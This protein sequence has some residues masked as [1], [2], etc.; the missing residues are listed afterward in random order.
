MAIHATVT[1][2]FI[3]VNGLR[4]HYA[5]WGNDRAQPMI[6]LHGLRSFARVWD[7]VAHALCDRYHILALDQRGR[8]DS[9]WA[10]DGNYFTEAYVSDLEQFVGQLRLDR[11]ILVG[12]SMGGANTIVYAARHPEKVAAAVIE[13]MGPRAANPSQ[14]MMRIGQELDETPKEFR[15]WAEAEAFW[16]NQRPLISQEAMQV[17]LQATLKQPPDGKIVWKYD[18]E[19]I[20]KA[21]LNTDPARQV[22]LWP[23]VRNLKCPTLVVRGGLSDI[24]S[25]ETAEA[26]AKDNPNLRWVEVPK[27]THSVHEDNLEGFNQEVGRFL[28]GLK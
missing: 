9:D 8:G 10:P 21:R 19:G 28:N 13:D 14:G 18:L 27:A 2:R 26:M 25:R 5:D 4:I 22:D 24:L 23:H 7:G 12:H 6:M 16:R 3:K 11:C 15:S 20:K 17:R 1:D